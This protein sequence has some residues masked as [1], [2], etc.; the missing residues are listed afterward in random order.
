M[1]TI[2]KVILFSIML[3]FSVGIMMTAIPAFNEY[4]GNT[5]GLSYDSNYGTDFQSQMNKSI[6]PTDQLDDAS[7]LFDRILDKLQL[8]IVKQFLEL[9]DRYMF[10]FV[11]MLHTMIGSYLDPAVRT[12]IFGIMRVLITIGYVLGAIWLWTGKDFR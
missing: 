2:F 7:D 11:Q 6:N 10:G 4:S 3:N 9:V 1:N 8:G 5:A 12:L